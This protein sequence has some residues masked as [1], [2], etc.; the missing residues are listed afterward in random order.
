MGPANVLNLKNSY[1]DI[2]IPPMELCSLKCLAVI[3]P[4]SPPTTAHAIIQKVKV[5]TLV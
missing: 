5:R 1:M 3:L 2:T 4:R